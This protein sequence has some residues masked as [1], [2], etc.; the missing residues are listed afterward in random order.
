MNLFFTRYK[1]RLSLGEKE[2]KKTLVRRLGWILAIVIAHT[3]T[4]Y[5]FEPVSLREA[6][7]VTVTTLT[8]VGYGDISATS[9]LGQVFTSVLCFLVGIPILASVW[10]AYASWRDEVR[11]LKRTGRYN[12][13]L[14]GHILIAN[15]PEDYSISQM[16]RLIKAIRSQ[17]ELA[18]KPIQ[19][20]TRHFNGD[21]LPQEL[22]DLGN[23]AHVNGEPSNEKTLSLATADQASHVIILRERK[24]ND[25]E[26]NSFNICSR[27]REF[28]K[29]AV[30]TVQV[31]DPN[32][33]SAKRLYRAGANN[34]LR[35][36]KAYPE[37]IALAMMTPGVNDLFED[38]LSV[39]GNEF[40]LIPYS[41]RI[42]WDSVQKLC[43]TKDFGVPVGL[44]RVVG[45]E[46][47]KSFC[48]AVLAPH[49]DFECE[50][51]G[52]YVLSRK[53]NGDSVS[54][55]D[56]QKLLSNDR[57]E[58]AE[59]CSKLY[60]LNL[61]VNQASPLDYLN[62]LFYQLRKTRKYGDTQ[63]IVV[64]QDIPD[65]VIYFAEHA[66]HDPEHD[67]L[68]DKVQLIDNV[69]STEIINDIEND[70]F[71]DNFDE[72]TIVA[73]LNNDDDSDPDGYAFEIIDLL[74]EEG[75]FQ[76]MIVAEV[77]SDD[78]RERLYNVGANHCL[79]P[80]RG[81]PGML[82]RTL[83][84]PGVEKAVEGFFRFNDVKIE[85][86]KV[87]DLVDDHNGS[88]TFGDIQAAAK[89][90]SSELVPLSTRCNNH[91]ADSICPP[92]D[93]SFSV[94]ECSVLLLSRS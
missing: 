34:L 58:R 10:D 91:F 17:E 23:I 71:K 15:F 25:P 43:E 88:A 7:W 13:D 2:I 72:K 82:A 69:P 32:S 89:T 3:A 11:D 42:R 22:V 52:I 19:I 74:R 44:H 75:G 53:N 85:K 65:S 51:E 4:F 27:I 54:D 70:A 39:D 48:Q 56:W 38:L 18:E 86:V 50:V 31:D 59:K 1:T 81:Y 83:T 93:Q 26:G 73:I 68:W 6:L 67:W 35:P 80:V 41:G 8:T 49:A 90:K 40:R 36:V 47:G 21:T 60:L 29:S 61:P 76:G 45:R 46:D 79:R 87:S 9:A 64:S 12:W 92:K 55:E 37:I 84:N 30:I 78:Q 20:M 94:D 62:K 77:E 63:I 66:K 14:E 57:I 24:D 33:R 28:N 16:V 5:A